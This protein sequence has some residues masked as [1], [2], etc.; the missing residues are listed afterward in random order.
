MTAALPGLVSGTNLL[1]VHGMNVTAADGN[2]LVL[3]ELVAG[4]LP[5]G[6]ES[7][8][9]NRP[10]PGGINTAPDSLGKVADTVFSPGRGFYPNAVVGAVPFNRASGI[11]ITLFVRET[12][13]GHKDAPQRGRLEGLGDAV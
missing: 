11:G 5:A 1:A 8:F 3:P 4:A 12:R 10:T 9:F 7:A 2:F 6:R 13:H